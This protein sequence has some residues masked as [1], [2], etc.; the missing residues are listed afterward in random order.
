MHYLL[1]DD[2]TG[3]T[4]IFQLLAQKIVRCIQ[5]ARSQGGSVKRVL[6][7]VSIHLVLIIHIEMKYPLQNKFTLQSKQVKIW[8]KRTLLHEKISVS[9][10]LSSFPQKGNE[11]DHYLP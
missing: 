8:E 1:P 5:L 6:V 4:F 10:M 11:T 3:V 9:L 2:V 7:L